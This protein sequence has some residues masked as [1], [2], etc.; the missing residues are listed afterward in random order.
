MISNVSTFS[1]TI[2]PCSVGQLFQLDPLNPRQAQCRCK[3]GYVSYGNSTNCYRP[4][5]RGPCSAQEVFTE[6]GVCII[7]PCPK[8]YLFL[9]QDKQCYRIGSRGPCEE[10]KIVTF[11]FDTRPSVDGISYNGVCG[12]KIRG[13]DKEIKYTCDR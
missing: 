2:G 8:A 1:D 3:Q 4:Y 10:D 12:C 9:P 6:E 7:K 5:T 13:C 11:D